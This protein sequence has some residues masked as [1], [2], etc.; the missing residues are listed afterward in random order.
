MSLSNLT[1]QVDITGSTAAATAT[2]AVRNAL[3]ARQPLHSQ[4]AVD[5]RGY[6][7][8]HLKS[9]ARHASAQA[10]GASPTGHRAKSAAGIEAEGTP[11]AALMRIPRNTGL[12]RAFYDMTILPTSGHKYLTIPACAATYGKSVRDFPEGTFELGTVQ[13]RFMAL[14]FRGTTNPAFWLRRRVH[15][16]QDRTLLPADEDFHRVALRSA[17]V[18]LANLPD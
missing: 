9:D 4:M 10:L 5:V 15:Q 14:V 18:F 1:L 7:Q 3:A 12:G 8:A 17:Q 16:R 6:A 2:Q 11:A 13:G